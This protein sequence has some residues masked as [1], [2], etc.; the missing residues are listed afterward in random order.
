MSF[1]A[2]VWLGLSWNPNIP[3]EHEWENGE[4]FV[5]TNWEQ[6]EPLANSNWNKAILHNDNAFKWEAKGEEWL[7]NFICEIDG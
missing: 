5:Y 2:D 6:G 3:E 7:F 1:E 4:S